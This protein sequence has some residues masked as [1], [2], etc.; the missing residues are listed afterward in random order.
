[1]VAPI[2]NDAELS[3]VAAQN[4][5]P[6]ASLVL[7]RST[8]PD[9]G[10]AVK[11]M[12]NRMTQAAR[13]VRSG[14]RVE[15]VATGLSGAS[16]Y[17]RADGGD[18]G[19]DE[20]WA[21]VYQ[22][23]REPSWSADASTYTDTK[24]EL[25]IIARRGDLLA[26]HC[27]G[28]LRSRLQRWLDGRVRPSFER[29]EPAVLNGAFLR[30]EAKGLW[31]RGAQ[32]PTANRPDSK[33][34]S[35]R[36]VE[37]SLN[38]FEDGGYALS[39]ARV[40]YAGSPERALKGMV[41]ATPRNSIVWNK[42]TVSFDEFVAVAADVLTLVE[43]VASSGAGVEQPYRVLAQRATSLAGVSGAFDIV[44]ASA[45]SLPLAT[46]IDDDLL[47]AITVLE[48]AT[49]VVNGI[50]GSADFTVDVGSASGMAGSLRCTVAQD[51]GN[52]KITIGLNVDKPASNQQVTRDILDALQT[53]S[54][55]LSIYYDSGHVFDGHSIWR[56]HVRTD[57]FPN[58]RFEDFTGYDI[59]REKPLKPGKGVNDTAQ[60]AAIG[61]N[62]DN[63][64]FAWV[65]SHY[66]DGW[67]ICDDRQG[68]VADFVHLSSDGDLTFIHVKKAESGEQ[69][70]IS[71]GPYEEVTAQATKNLQ[72][73]DQDELY[74]ALDSPSFVTASWTKGVRVANRSEFLEQLRHRPARQKKSVV[75][76]QPHVSQVLYN[77]VQ[78]PSSATPLE[79]NALRL[80][81]L[82]TLLNAS[83]GAVTGLGADL[84]VIGSLS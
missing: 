53:A 48:E 9:N 12:A 46:D 51:R 33:Q 49:L 79:A 27:P 19:I 41:G 77:A 26:V 24:H 13:S 16:D 14:T 68:E 22:V 4:L 56:R 30:G 80:M 32:S 23:R 66:S 35:G 55:L 47:N 42:P 69:R 37:V 59:H 20:L 54:E 83:R 10:L 52:F 25:G 50:D 21:F 1:L 63:S 84:H 28:A 5:V 45:E 82:E 29:V 75:I 11:S 81:Q 17:L 67:L 71:A 64:L 2:E 74:R 15:I 62:G 76:L 65:V 7:L 70:Q 40:A 60:H 57:P 43:E 72:R 61:E 31:L 3:Q 36:N 34:V 6:F 39:S 78:P 73:L 58:W 18:E 44:V 38:P 8:G